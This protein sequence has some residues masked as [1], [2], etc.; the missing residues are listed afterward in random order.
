[1]R[2]SGRTEFRND[3]FYLQ[4]T[5]K[6]VERCANTQFCPGL[7][8]LLH[9]LQTP[10]FNLSMTD[11]NITII[12]LKSMLFFF[13]VTKYVYLWITRRCARF[14]YTS[15]SLQLTEL[16]QMKSRMTLIPWKNFFLRYDGV[17]NGSLYECVLALI[18]LCLESSSSY[19]ICFRQTRWSTP[20][21]IVP[22]YN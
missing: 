17:V 19:G 7:F 8:I 14:K 6:L 4:Q 21:P 9:L 20:D 12:F 1:M 22:K 15:R 13:P 18:M 5:F 16:I 11:I 2:I 3:K 10:Y